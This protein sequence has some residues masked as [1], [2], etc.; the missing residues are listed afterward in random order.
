MKNKD[1]F[2]RFSSK[3]GLSLIK[4]WT[5]ILLLPCTAFGQPLSGIYSIAAS[6]GDYSSITSAVNDLVLNGVNAPVV[7]NISTGTYPEQVTIPEIGG[8][9]AINTISFQS[10]SGDSTDVVIQYSANSSADNWVV[11]LDG[12]DYISFKHLTIKAT[13]TSYYA[14]AV[15]LINGAEHNVFENN[16]IQSSTSSSS[17][18]RPVVLYAGALN[19]YNTFENNVIEGGYYGI[20]C[21]GTYSSSLAQSNVFKGNEIKDFYQREI[22]AYSRR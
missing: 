17:S 19:Q 5:L 10:A 8:S 21:R 14:Y 1:K 3:L 15:H 12:A 20:Y 18:A 22:Y 4:T 7:F 16:I 11:K 6:G 2:L 9:S 13:G